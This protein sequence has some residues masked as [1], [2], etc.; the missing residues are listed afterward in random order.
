M[1]Q[2]FECLIDMF[3]A[4]YLFNKIFKKLEKLRK[5]MIAVLATWICLNQDRSEPRTKVLINKKLIYHHWILIPNG[6]AETR[7]NIWP[8]IP[9]LC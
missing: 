2:K 5:N 4:S 9:N 6:L 8:N 3:L 1:H 7:P